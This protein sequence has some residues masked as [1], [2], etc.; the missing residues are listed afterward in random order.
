MALY[1]DLVTNIRQFFEG[2]QR[3]GSPTGT[4]AVQ[5]V[6]WEVIRIWGLTV[7][8][9]FCEWLQCHSSL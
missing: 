5:G 7:P 4:N 2:L 1:E 8:G 9:I 6:G 3:P